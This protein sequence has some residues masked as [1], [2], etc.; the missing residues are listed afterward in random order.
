MSLPEFWKFS[1]LAPPWREVVWASLVVNIIQINCIQGFRKSNYQKLW[2]LTL[3]T[4]L[5]EVMRFYLFIFDKNVM[6][7]I[8]FQ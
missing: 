7:S 8:S 2:V 1:E 6:Q 3:L 5:A 4:L